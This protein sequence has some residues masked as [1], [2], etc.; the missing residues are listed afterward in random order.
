MQAKKKMGSQ[1]FKMENDVKIIGHAAIAGKKEGEGP[2]SSEFDAVIDDSYWGEETWEAA[3]I[4]F[5]KETIMRAVY[6]S[7]KSFP[8]I[9]LIF[10]GDLLN[11]CISSTFGIRSLNIP[12]YGIFGACSTMAES[13]SLGAMAVD[14]G[15][16]EN[17]ICGTSSHFACA[18]RQFRQ[19]MEYG[20]QRPRTSQWTVTAAG[21]CV[22]SNEGDGP[23]IT[24]V[25]PGKIIDHGIKDPN[26]MGAA[27]A[28]AAVETILAHFKDTC[29]KPDFYDLIVTGDLGEIGHS[30]VQDLTAKNNLILGNRYKDCGMMIFDREK[31]DVHCGGS[32]CGCSASVLCGHILNEM[33]K[34]NLNNVLFVATGALMSTTSQQQGESIPGIAHAVAISNEKR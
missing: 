21:M 16:C 25:T 7:G 32:G 4:K 19:P 2:L 18:E 28:P 3:E 31:Q 10:A 24:H 17:V 29:R 22:L 23:F 1:T 11:Q 34:G 30:V 5:Q 15:F 9:D 20:G 14:G 13:L 26:N 6:K 27:M 12:F 33:K 8:D